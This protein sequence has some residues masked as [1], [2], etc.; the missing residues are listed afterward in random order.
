MIKGDPIPGDS[1]VSLGQPIVDD[2]EENVLDYANS[3]MISFITLGHVSVI[4]CILLMV[5]GPGCSKIQK[6]G[7]AQHE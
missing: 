4:H 1:G 5:D 6:G 7:F 3:C 2:N